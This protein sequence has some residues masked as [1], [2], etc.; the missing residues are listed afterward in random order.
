MGINPF[1]AK[2]IY[3]KIALNSLVKVETLATIDSKATTESAEFSV[4]GDVFASATAFVMRKKNGRHLS[5]LLGKSDAE[6]IKENLKYF[7]KA[8]SLMAWSF[9]PIPLSSLAF[10]LYVYVP[11]GWSSEFFIIG[12]FV[13]VAVIL[14]LA[15]FVNFG[16]FSVRQKK[17]GDK[18]WARD[19]I[20]VEIPRSFRNALSRKNLLLWKGPVLSY[21]SDSVVE[22]LP[23]EGM[24]L[25]YDALVLGNDVVQLV[26]K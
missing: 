24:K 8:G 19:S 18:L 10:P 25:T 13:A 11:E 20:V 5:P 2:K 6:D 1:T 12:P 9:I 3:E 26:R 4:D 16:R 21:I 23:S 14:L 17:L 15:A 22:V 7:A